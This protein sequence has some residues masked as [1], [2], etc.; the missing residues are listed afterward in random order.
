MKG[1]GREDELK[2]RRRGGGGEHKDEQQSRGTKK[3][4][5]AR[6]RCP[7]TGFSA[8]RV[9]CPPLQ[10]LCVLGVSESIPLFCTK[11][12]SSIHHPQKSYDLW[13]QLL[14][15]SAAM[16]EHRLGHE[17]ELCK[18]PAVFENQE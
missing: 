7:R 5:L 8:L 15:G 16:A 14:C 12:D 9:L 4:T 18:S 10:H 6:T 17:R 11:D 2:Q 3:A 13:S 1:V